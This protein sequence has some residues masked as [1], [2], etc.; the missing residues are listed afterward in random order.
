MT[1]PQDPEQWIKH[2]GYSSVVCEHHQDI[3]TCGRCN[4]FEPGVA[5][6]DNSTFWQKLRNPI[7][8]WRIRQEVRRLARQG[9]K[10]DSDHGRP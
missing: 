2:D 4:V 3:M 6:V 10:Q 1:H 8:W 7:G 5:V 9:I